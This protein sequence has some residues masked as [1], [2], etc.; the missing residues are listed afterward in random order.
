MISAYFCAD[1]SY[2]TSHMGHF[3]GLNFDKLLASQPLVDA[4]EW[5]VE[6]SVGGCSWSSTL[7][8]WACT[9]TFSDVWFHFAS[10]CLMGQDRK[11]S[12]FCL[13]VQGGKHLIMN[14]YRSKMYNSDHDLLRVVSKSTVKV[15]SSIP[16][17]SS[18]T[19]PEARTRNSWA[20]DL[21]FLNRSSLRMDSSWWSDLSYSNMLY[22]VAPQHIKT[23]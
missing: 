20:E 3:L 15:S 16:H 8:S 4:A 14:M 9:R 19:I 17:F 23:S 10:P 22:I 6:P 5:H 21:K 18:W 2:P 13:E 7:G 12:I 11:S 1:W